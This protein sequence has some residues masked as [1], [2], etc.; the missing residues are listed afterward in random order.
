M[1]LCCFWQA[2]QVRCCCLAVAMEIYETLNKRNG[3][4]CCK[5]RTKS[6]RKKKEEEGWYSSYVAST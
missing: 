4:K 5:T 1:M 2:L 3:V 6:G